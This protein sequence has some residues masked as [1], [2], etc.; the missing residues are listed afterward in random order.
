MKLLGMVIATRRDLARV[1]RLAHAAR[2]QD[3]DVT[4][5]AMDEG[6]AALAADRATVA[7][8]LDDEVVVIAC[9]QS[10]HDRGLK[11]KDVGCTLGSQIDHAELAHKADRF[12]GFT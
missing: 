1:A 4:I 12:L 8:L 11:E 10:A 2:A 5:F 7:A 3:N 9:G 6:V